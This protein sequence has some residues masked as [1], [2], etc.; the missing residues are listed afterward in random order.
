MAAPHVAAVAA[1]VLEADPTLTT[2]PEGPCCSPRW[3]RRTAF[4][5]SVSGGRIK[6]GIAV[7]RAFHTGL[8]DDSDG[9]DVDRCRRRC[10][11]EVS[12]ATGLPEGCPIPHSDG[13]GVADWYDNCVVVDNA[14]QADKNRDGEGDACDSDI[15]GD[16]VANGSDNCPT[17][18]NAS[19]RNGD[20]DALGDACDPDRDNDGVPDTRDLC[21]DLSSTEANGCPPGTTTTTQGADP[22]RDGVADVTDA[23]RPRPR[24][25]ATAARWPRSPRCR[26]RRASAP[27]PSRSRRAGLATVTVTVERKKGKRWV[28]VARKTLATSKKQRRR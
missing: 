6:A 27:P 22:D 4:D 10:P 5:D 23:A 18:S 13:D 9:D 11:N 21:A 17:T 1:L 25:R 14:D 2:T 7:E 12:P 15:D 19:Q 16:S 28:R 3:T 20:G 24:R 8:D 26:P